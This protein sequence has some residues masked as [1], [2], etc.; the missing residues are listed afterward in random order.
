VAAE[1]CSKAGTA[2]APA[3]ELAPTG[4]NPDL[5]AAPAHPAFL[6]ISRNFR[7]LKDADSLWEFELIYAVRSSSTLHPFARHIPACGF[8]NFCR[9]VRQEESTSFKS[10]YQFRAILN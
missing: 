3:R 5:T 4:N 9:F 6:S 10:A 8:R 7:R 1:I 2:T